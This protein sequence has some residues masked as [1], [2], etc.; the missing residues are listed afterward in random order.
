MHVAFCSAKN[1][2]LEWKILFYYFEII[3]KILNR[4]IY[5]DS[6]FS[7]HSGCTAIDTSKPFAALQFLCI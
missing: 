5:Y 2:A 1:L 4:I 6:S 7:L 3:R